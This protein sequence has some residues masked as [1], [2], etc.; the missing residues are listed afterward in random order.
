MTEQADEIASESATRSLA[1]PESLASDFI[2]KRNYISGG[3]L[4]RYSAG[5]IG[6]VSPSRASQ[7][8]PKYPSP[9]VVS[10]EK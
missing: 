7:P 8:V 1:G 4:W 6:R 2:L 5:D 10:K 9:S 3:V